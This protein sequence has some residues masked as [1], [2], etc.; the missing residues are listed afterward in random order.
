LK[1]KIENVRLRKLELSDKETL[2]KLLNNKKIWDNLRDYIPYPYRI[3]DA[4]LFIN[5]T[6]EN[7]PQQV[8]GIEF[9][10]E[11]CGVIS[12]IVQTDIYRKSAEIGY[13]LGEKYWGNG[14]M[15]KAVKLITEY[16]FENLDIIRIFTG[17]FEF[18][19]ASIKVLE[20]NGYL[21][22]GT[23]KNAIFKNGK[24]WNEHR[25]FKLKE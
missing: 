20:K 16:G 15:S 22:E 9:K 12:L 23:F 7:N 5:L 19:V 8:F 11:L 3:E 1:V 6:K 2:A 14:I 10:R 13:W 24:I 25:Y 21:K 4:E 17:I 18:N